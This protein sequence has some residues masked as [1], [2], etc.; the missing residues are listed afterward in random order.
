MYSFYTHDYIRILFLTT[1]QSP[2]NGEGIVVSGRLG[3]MLEGNSWRPFFISTN[4]TS[5]GVEPFTRT[6]RMIPSGGVAT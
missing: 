2:P 3:T 6:F 5:I 4:D 1:V